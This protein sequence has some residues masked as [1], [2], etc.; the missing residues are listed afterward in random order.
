MSVHFKDTRC[1]PATHSCSEGCLQRVQGE[2][3]INC[4]IGAGIL[5]TFNNKYARV[6][7]LAE[8]T[9]LQLSSPLHNCFPFGG[10]EDVMEPYQLPSD[11]CALRD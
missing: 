5:H 9:Q 8:A 10:A 1:S 3:C 11:N 7:R 2:P 4:T 6:A